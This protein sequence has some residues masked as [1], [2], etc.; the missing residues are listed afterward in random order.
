MFEKLRHGF[1][2]PGAGPA[3]IAAREASLGITLPEDY[4]AFLRTSNGFNDD[5]GKGYLILWNIDEL[6]MA[7]GYEIFAL[8]PDRFLIGSNGGPTAYGILAGNYI[9]IPFVLSGPWQD[10]VRVLGGSFEAFI[11]A[12][13]AG[14]GW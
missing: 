6:A 14:D 9:S 12:I 8:Q 3:E 13:E 4:K 5:L 1:Q 10:E 11:A 7:D 2:L